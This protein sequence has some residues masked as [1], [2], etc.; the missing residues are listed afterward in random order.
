MN[1]IRLVL[2]AVVLLF[3]APSHAEPSV[4]AGFSPEGSAHALVLK[5]IG[6]AKQS[7]QLL[8]YSFQAQDIM[9]ALLDARKRGVS[10]RV[11]VDKKRNL[12]ASSQKAM[13]FVTH[14][15]VEVRTSDRFHVHHD[16]AIIVD[17]ETVL[18]GSFNFA[19]SA[20][21]AN[22]ENVVVI[23]GMPE[24]AKQYLAHWQSRWDGGMPFPGR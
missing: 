19:A 9:Q 15:G 12:V 3:A 21:T 22:S 20:E 4:Q 13:R 8:A 7:I 10:V 17:G 2:L 1:R 16:K 5:T 11:V 14:G 23:R 6:E 18:T 24:I